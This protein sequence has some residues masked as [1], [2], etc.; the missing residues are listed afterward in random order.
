MT[1][2]RHIGSMIELLESS[3]CGVGSKGEASNLK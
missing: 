2:N 3:R 1:A